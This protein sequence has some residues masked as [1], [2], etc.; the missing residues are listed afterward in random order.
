MQLANN[1]IGEAGDANID[2]D[3]A[4]NLI[5]VNWKQ[6]GAHLEIINQYPRCVCFNCGMTM[7][8]NKAKDS[9]MPSNPRGEEDCRAYRVF[10]YY[11]KLVVAKLQQ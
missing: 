9:R 1:L 10:E 7:Y 5:G 6:L 11:I 8:P 4:T 3:P 2:T